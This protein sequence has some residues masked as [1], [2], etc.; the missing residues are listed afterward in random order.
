MNKMHGLGSFLIT[1]LLFSGVVGAET[2]VN[3][4]SQANELATAITVYKSPT[5]GCCTGW[6]EHLS[7]RGFEVTVESMEDVSPVKNRLKVPENL[8]SC[9]TAVING[10]VVE[11]HVPAQD[12]TRLLASGDQRTAG[13]AV[14]GMPHGTPGMETGRK[15]PF[16][17]VAFDADGNLGQFSRYEDY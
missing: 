11:G 1:L 12:I 13:I 8:R 14:P 7:E 9:H 3:E 10:Y 16:T 5:C 6:V 15:D 17:V 2:P 4:A